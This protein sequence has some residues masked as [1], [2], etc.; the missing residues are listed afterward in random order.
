[1]E[2][3]SSVKNE[4]EELESIESP[5]DEVLAASSEPGEPLDPLDSERIQSIRD[6][7]SSVIKESHKKCYKKNIKRKKLGAA[8]YSVCIGRLTILSACKKYGV[9]RATL[10]NYIEK[11]RLRLGR[12]LPPQKQFE[13]SRL[14]LNYTRKNEMVK[15][16]SKAKSDDLRGRSDALMPIRD[17]QT[18]TIDGI[19]VPK[20]MSS[21]TRLLKLNQID[22]S[23]ARR[24]IGTK[25]EL[26]NK[27]IK[28]I[29]KKK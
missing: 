23:K 2:E 18:V 29:F 24:F 7:I 13:K 6:F 10:V 14:A 25:I 19:T 12:I 8:L 4:E 16:L 26:R 11:A 21:L 20:S 22:Y 1:E 9:C 5:E 17:D 15:R 3:K 27:L 28:A